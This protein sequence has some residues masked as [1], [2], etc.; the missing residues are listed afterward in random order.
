MVRLCSSAASSPPV[1]QSAVDRPAGA[2]VED[3][4]GKISN[5]CDGHAG[6]VAPIE[7]VAGFEIARPLLADVV[8]NP[9]V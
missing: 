4:Q 5:A 7:E 9:E 3:F 1:P 6:D 2:R 8:A